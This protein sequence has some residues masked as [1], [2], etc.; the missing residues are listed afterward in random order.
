MIEV[1]I[2]LGICTFCIVALVGL[3]ST[4]LQA[5]RESEDQIQAANL[6]S[7]IVST[8]AASPTNNTSSFGIPPAA[9][10]GPY[11]NA[12]NNGTSLTNIIGYDD[13]LTNSAGAAYQI[14][15]RAGTNAFT[16]SQ[17]SQVY[18]MLSWP[19]SANPAS[20]MAKHYEVLTYIPLR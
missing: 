14:S 4:G 16:G 13:R 10:T 8:C 6:A 18:V 17:L 2:A 19:A 5:S 11:T 15:C 9:I 3:F 20:T 12:Y 1:V 7:L